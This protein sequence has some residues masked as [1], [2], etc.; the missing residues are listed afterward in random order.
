MLG[1]TWLVP[2]KYATAVR[3]GE[4]LKRQECACYA[5]RTSLIT[6]G[7]IFLITTSIAIASGESIFLNRYDL[8]CSG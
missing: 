4:H 1:R 8:P 3:V 2:V 7:S 6:M 5:L